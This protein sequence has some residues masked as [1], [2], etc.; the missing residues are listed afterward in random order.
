[1]TIVI[2]NAKNKG[3]WY[4]E[5]GMSDRHSS[6]DLTYVILIIKTTHYKGSYP[7]FNAKATKV[8]KVRWVTK[9]LP[10]GIWWDKWTRLHVGCKIYK[11][12]DTFLFIIQNLSIAYT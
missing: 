7:Y 2:V 10:V 1:M 9:V 3:A 5:L 8:G 6:R 11:K 4:W 12:K